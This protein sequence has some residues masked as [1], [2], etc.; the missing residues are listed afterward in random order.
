MCIM[1]ADIPLCSA[2]STH[3][4]APKRT[5]LR[6]NTLDRNMDDEKILSP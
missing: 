2:I 1:D 6:L 3:P 4:M 5:V